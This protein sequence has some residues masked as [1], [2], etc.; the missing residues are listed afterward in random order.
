M[1]T[2][3][4]VFKKLPITYKGLAGIIMPRP[5]HDEDDYDAM[6]EMAD[7][8]AG[9]DLSADQEEYLDVIARFISD[10]EQKAHGIDDSGVSPLEMLK[11]LLEENQM[12]GSDLGRL[13]GSRT[14]GPAI[15]SGDRQLSKAHIRI[16]AEYFKVEA[17]LFL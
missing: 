13:L 7:C 2:Q 3:E 1:Q 9:H 5:V 16:L 6:V 12:N 17:G 10:Y 15:L 14:L 4:L 11:F 8:L